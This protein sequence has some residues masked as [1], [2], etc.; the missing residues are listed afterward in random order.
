MN[1]EQFDN[2]I[3]DMMIKLKNNFIDQ[4]FIIIMDNARIHRISSLQKIF[5]EDEFKNQ[6]QFKMLPPYSPFLNP[7]ERVFSQIKANIKSYLRMHNDELIATSTLPW[8]QKG[9]ARYCI[10]EKALNESLNSV[11]Q[12]NIS[13]YALRTASYFAQV[14]QRQPIF[15]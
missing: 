8:G 13:Q 15:E 11:T 7:I 2:F 4:K 10:L 12:Q 3:R 1:G 6:F 9:P 5:D 14:L